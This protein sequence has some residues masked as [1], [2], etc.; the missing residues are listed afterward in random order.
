VT[1]GFGMTAC[2]AALGIVAGALHVIA[3]GV[4]CFL[5][6]LTASGWNGVF[7]AEVA[8]E[9]PPGEIARITGGVMVTA[10]AG[11]ILGPVAFA[12]AA[13][14]ASLGAGYVALAGATLAGSVALGRARAVPPRLV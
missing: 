11:L 2:A 13:A 4:L 12:A 9:S 14:A 1:I 3:L 10:Y 7:L 6:G 5:F 8:R